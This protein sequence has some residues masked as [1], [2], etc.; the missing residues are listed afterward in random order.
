LI[1]STETDPLHEIALQRVS[2][3]L[4]TSLIERFW[5][6]DGYSLH[7]EF[8][9][10]LDSLQ[11]LNLPPPSIVSNTDPALVKI[12]KNLGVSAGSCGAKGIKNDEIFTTW[13]LEKEKQEVDF[14]FDVLD[15]LNAETTAREKL[16]PE[17]VLVVGDELVAFVLIRSY[18]LTGVVLS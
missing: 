4:S 6:S 12:L 11:T 7:S 14:W 10:F 15:R 5:G 16:K 1:P 13:D 18:L 8:H 3:P 2:S 17:E 9:S